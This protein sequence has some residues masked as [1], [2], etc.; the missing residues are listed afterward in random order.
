[1]LSFIFSPSA[2]ILLFIFTLSGCATPEQAE[3]ASSSNLNGVW[4]IE[5][6]YS[7]ANTQEFTNNY[8]NV[9]I[10]DKGNTIDIRHCNSNKNKQFT[11]AEEYLTNENNEKLR[12][13]NGSIIESVNVPEIIQLTKTKKSD[14]LNAGIITLNSDKF[15]YI[16]AN[17]QVCAQRIVSNNDDAGI[18]HFIFTLPFE[19]SFIEIELLY[20]EMIDGNLNN[21]QSLTFSSPDF[22]PYYNAFTANTLSGEAILL[23]VTD[24]S[25]IFEFDIRTALNGRFPDDHIVGSIQVKY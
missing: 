18:Y 6:I 3:T 15:G 25:A 24:A 17:Q 11:R 19:N 7:N 12:V 14:F 23:E 21:I 10:R 16:Y 13:V 9:A 1:M 22:R 8:Y 20:N 5:E 4:K 2:L